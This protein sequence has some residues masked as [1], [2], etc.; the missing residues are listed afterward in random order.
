[1]CEE[2][3]RATTALPGARARE[4]IRGEEFKSLS[5]ENTKKPPNFIPENAT[6]SRKQKKSRVRHLDLVFVFSPA[7]S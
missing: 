6:S 4:Q 1:M 7:R 3:R 5:A 2:E